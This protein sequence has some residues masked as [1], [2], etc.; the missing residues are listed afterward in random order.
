MNCS[1]VNYARQNIQ[2][3]EAI[4]G[5]FHRWQGY[6]FVSAGIGVG[7]GRSAWRGA[8]KAMSGCF[9][10]WGLASGLAWPQQPAG[11]PEGANSGVKAKLGITV[12]DGADGI[13]I[14]KGKTTV[15]PLV[16]VRD[17]WNLPIAGALVTFE[18]P[19]GRPSATF[20][21][22]NKVTSVMTDANGRAMADQMRPV[23]KGE[24]QIAIR[25]FYRGV[26]ESHTIE[27]TNFK[28]A[29]EAQKSVKLPAYG[30]A[31]SGGGKALIAVGVAGAAAAGVALA[32]AH[33]SSSSQSDCSSLFNQFNTELNTATSLPTGSTQ[34]IV[35]SQTMFN[36]LGA[37]C[38]CAGGPGELASN[39]ALSQDLQTLLSAGS[40][41]GFAVPS[42]CG[43]F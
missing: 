30:N 14:L 24:F 5:V 38:S 21:N 28:T 27:Q 32:L 2:I 12:I 33:K 1:K 40:G 16:E 41:A 18:L 8:L 36:D 25:A 6:A 9:I 19:N 4:F 34:W 20:V 37:Y 42:S 15:R 13:N 10:V 43:S 17:A 31:L 26:S 11:R 22:G 7:S 3:G 35:A 39:P 23:G 29:G